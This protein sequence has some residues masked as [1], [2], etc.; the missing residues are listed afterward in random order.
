VRFLSDTVFYEPSALR[1]A[2]SGGVGYPRTRGEPVEY[3]TLRGG[4][5][6]SSP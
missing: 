5:L 2:T 4:A 1:Q 6:L 3:S